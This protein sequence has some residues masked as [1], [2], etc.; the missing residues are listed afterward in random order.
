[1]SSFSVVADAHVMGG[2]KVLFA[3]CYECMTPSVIKAVKGT[4]M[5]VEGIAGIVRYEHSI[6]VFPRGRFC[7]GECGVW[8][9]M[10]QYNRAWAVRSCWGS[11]EL[12]RK[13]LVCE[14]CAESE[15]FEGLAR[16]AALTHED[17][18]MEIRTNAEKA[19][20]MA[21]VNKWKKAAKLR[22]ERRELTLKSAWVFRGLFEGRREGWQQAWATFLVHV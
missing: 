10:D 22:K 9:V 12:M 3:G 19:Y 21:L 18:Y 2:E 5:E 17:Y 14:E 7:C 1:M 20:C 11:C 6:R 16:F 15:T 13:S 8:K 4:E